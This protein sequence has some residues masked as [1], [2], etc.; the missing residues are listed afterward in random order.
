M[1]RALMTYVRG[2]NRPWLF[3]L[4]LT[5]EW[6]TWTALLVISTTST[7]SETITWPTFV[8]DAILGTIATIIL[9]TVVIIVKRRS[10]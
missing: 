6:F 8:K 9:S 5:L 2:L 10:E 3:L 7:T 1:L 4:L